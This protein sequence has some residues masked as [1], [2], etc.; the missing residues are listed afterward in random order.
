M[1]NEMFS[2]T[3]VMI[4]CSGEQKAFDVSPIIGEKSSHVDIKVVESNFTDAFYQFHP[5]IS[6]CPKSRHPPE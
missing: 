6:Q 3:C 2:K 1:S 4:K 5:K